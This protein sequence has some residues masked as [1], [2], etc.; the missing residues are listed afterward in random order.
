MNAHDPDFEADLP[1]GAYQ[2]IPADAPPPLDEDELPPSQLL[3]GAHDVRDPS[4]DPAIVATVRTDPP[5]PTGDP[6]TDPTVLVDSAAVRA[7]QLPT[8]APHA[9]RA[10]EQ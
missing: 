10:W 3:T 5:S 1:T 6:R 9:P 4:D 2:P 8:G 7:S